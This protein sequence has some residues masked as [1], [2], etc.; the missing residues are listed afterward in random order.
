METWRQ[1]ITAE[2]ADHGETWSDIETCT[3]T[4]AQLDEPFY[5]SYGSTYGRPFTVWTAQRVYFP[6]QYDGAEWCAS[7][8]RH[9]DGNPTP[10]V[11]GG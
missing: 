2:M 1:L 10:H 8:A 11:G 6:A 7:V 9:P 3:L 5:S 4:D